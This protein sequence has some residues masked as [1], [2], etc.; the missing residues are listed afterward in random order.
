MNRILVSAGIATWLATGGAAA[1]SD[2]Y[3]VGGM[4]V[5]ALSGAYQFRDPATQDLLHGYIDQMPGAASPNTSMV[6][7]HVCN[8]DKVL[9]IEFAKLKGGPPCRTFGHGVWQAWTLQNG[10]L[11][12]SGPTGNTVAAIDSDSL[13]ASLQPL[14][15]ANKSNE[16]RAFSFPSPSGLTMLGVIANQGDHD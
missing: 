15:K 2:H 10:K 1:Q 14:L 13:P 11:V 9:H 4:Q 6:D 3:K 8:T 12:A 7:F 16:V 5:T